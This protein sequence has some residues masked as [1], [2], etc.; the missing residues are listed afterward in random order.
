MAMDWAGYGDYAVQPMEE[1]EDEEDFYSEQNHVN[2]IDQ[3]QTTA[4]ASAVQQVGLFQLHLFESTDLN[5]RHSL[6]RS[7]PQTLVRRSRT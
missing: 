5:A 3:M 6:P 1:I 2:G 4:G 7:R